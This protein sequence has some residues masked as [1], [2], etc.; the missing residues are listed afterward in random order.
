[1]ILPVFVPV[2]VFVALPVFA[3]PVDTNIPGT[4]WGHRGY[5]LKINQFT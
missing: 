2:P 5:Q 3:L 4:H 1:M